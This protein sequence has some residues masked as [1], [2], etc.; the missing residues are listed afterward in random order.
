[1]KVSEG[2]VKRENEVEEN[3]GN[4]IEK[5]RRQKREMS[6]TRERAGRAKVAS[7]RCDVTD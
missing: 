2:K 5:E 7:K 6:V 3:V 4:R 1:M